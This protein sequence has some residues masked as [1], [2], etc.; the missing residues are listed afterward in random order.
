MRIDLGTRRLLAL[1]FFGMAGTGCVAQSPIPTPVGELPGKPFFVQKKWTIGGEG[2]WDYLTLDPAAQQLFIAHGKVV[3]IVDVSSG[4]V[5]GV[6]KGMQDAHQIALDDHGQ[7][8]YVSDG[9]ANAVKVFDRQT[10]E[11]I[12]TVPTCNGPRSAVFEPASGL[13]FAVC[14]GDAQESSTPRRNVPNGASPRATESTIKS[15]MTIIDTRTQKQLANLLLPGRLGAAQADGKG[16]IYVNITDRNQIAYFDAPGLQ[17][18]L[19]RPAPAPRPANPAPATAPA[20]KTLPAAPKVPL[21]PSVDWSDASQDGQTGQA[22]PNGLHRFRLGGD[23]VQPKS[24][25]IDSANLRLFAAC[26]NRKMQVLN[27]ATGELIATLPIGTGTDAIAY[28]SD[29]GLIYASNGGGTGS[30]TII[31]QHRT[32]SYAVIQELP[33]QARAR[34]LAVDPGTGIVYLVTNINGFDLTKRSDSNDLHT[35]P[36]V[37]T[38]PVS[39]SFQVLVIGTGED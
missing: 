14:P 26:D 36:V 19:S 21:V 16:T 4:T 22:I 15:T 33:T 28:D 7:Y 39:G 38:T 5:F 35:L 32:D 12:A 1:L 29:R 23:C 13:V 17:G 9:P 10:M 37:Q 8:G 20:E 18:Q 24:L 34:T 2:N 31:R 25:A 6:V 3:Q 27:A 30:L 11:V